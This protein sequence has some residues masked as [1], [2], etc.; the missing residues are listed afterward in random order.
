[1][2]LV[3]PRCDALCLAH[4]CSPVCDFDRVNASA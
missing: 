2:R 4:F 3:E 1:M